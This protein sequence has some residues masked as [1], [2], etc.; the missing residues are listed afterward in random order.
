MLLMQP[1]GIITGLAGN[2]QT[3]AFKGSAAVSHATSGFAT[4]VNL[5]EPGLMSRQPKRS[6][7]AFH[8][9]RTKSQT[10]PVLADL[11]CLPL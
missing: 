3:F 1:G 2:E 9:L 7:R 8:A 11:C 5:S 10:Q 6:V 4:S